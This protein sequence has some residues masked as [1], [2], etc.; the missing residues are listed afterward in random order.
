MATGMINIKFDVDSKGAVKN[1]RAVGDAFEKTSKKTEGWV[2]AGFLASIGNKALNASLGATKKAIES[3]LVPMRDAIFEIGVMGDKIAKQARMIGVTAEQFQVMEYAAT[4]SG[5][6]MTAVVNGMKKLGRVMVDAQ[7]G[8]R[9]IKDT[10][11]ALGITLEKDNGTLRE[12]FDVFLDL[13]DKSM[14]LGESAERTGVQ[15]LLLGRSG[16]EM[17]NLFAQGSA[18]I[19]DL[20][21]ELVD[22]GAIMGKQTLDDAEGLVD[23]MADMEHAFRGVK[24]ELSAN[25]L[26][27]FTEFAEELSIWLATTDFTKVRELAEHILDL[28]IGMIRAVDAAAELNLF[29]KKE[30]HRIQDAANASEDLFN[31][32]QGGVATYEDIKKASDEFYSDEIKQIRAVGY[33]QK[34]AGAGL[35][36][37]IDERSTEAF[38]KKAASGALVLNQELQ[39]TSDQLEDFSSYLVESGGDAHAADEQMLEL[40]AVSETQAA[41]LILQASASDDLASSEEKLR[42]HWQGL[43]EDGKEGNKTLSEREALIKANREALLRA[44]A[45]LGAAREA[46]REKAKADREAARAARELLATRKEM[47]SWETAQAAKREESLQAL[48]ETFYKLDRDQIVESFKAGLLEEHQYTQQMAAAAEQELTAEWSRRNEIIAAA[49]RQGVIQKQEADRLLTQSEQQ[50]QDDRVMMAEEAERS[51]AGMQADR[52]ASWAEATGAIS[53][54]FGAMQSAILAGHGEESQAAQAAAKKMFVLEQGLALAQAVMSMA[55]AI[56]KANELGYPQSIPA[57]VAAGATGAAQVATIAAT[58]ISGIAD[59]GLAPDV[60]RAAG[61]NRHTAI[62]I[63]NDEMVLDP[64]GTRHITE[65]LEA[66]KAQMVG[67]PQE[68]FIRTTVELDGHVLGE[69]V[70]K[71][72]IR[73][74]E[75]GLAYTNRIRQG[76]M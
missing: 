76:Y 45:Q 26:P 20:R 4:R 75:R 63:R 47:W 2:K 66:Q 43:I 62:A 64:V 14:I 23:K 35:Y 68:Q 39:L 52:I 15:M 73:Q 32:I 28:S 50:F 34:M 12:T 18:G 25:L 53:G 71:R 58:T 22:L 41:L 38:F 42:E 46:E 49:L 27:T 33:Q 36:G 13:A 37:G 59:A 24:I 48:Y 5:T 74:A 30:V 40:S 70:D 7:N 57:M 8:S 51:L 17:S 65:M 9:Q 11:D 21:Q 67:A 29:P 55:V 16:T 44:V 60:L 69:A 3:L 56:G 72:L 10:F 61:L 19:L 6:S 54:M 1:I 31:R